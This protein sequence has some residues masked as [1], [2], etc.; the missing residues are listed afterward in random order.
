MFWGVSLEIAGVGLTAKFCL[1]KGVL[2]TSWVLSTGW[3][4]A[5]ENVSVAWEWD[6]ATG[7]VSVGLLLLAFVT[8]LSWAVDARADDVLLVGVSFAMLVGLSFTCC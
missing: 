3:F 4:A 5:G 1:V 2:E 6:S 7:C 8:R